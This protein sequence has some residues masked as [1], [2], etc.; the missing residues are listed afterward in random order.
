[1]LVR[2]LVDGQ[3]FSTATST[4]DD[5]QHAKITHTT[6]RRPPLLNYAAGGVEIDSGSA[7]FV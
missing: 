6:S 2:A 1:M 5:S 7:L 3:Q 4:L